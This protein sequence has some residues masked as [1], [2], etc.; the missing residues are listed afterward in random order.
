MNNHNNITEE[1]TLTKIIEEQEPAT[2]GATATTDLSKEKSPSLGSSKSK[3]K[4]KKTKNSAK[5]ADSSVSS[6]N[7]PTIFKELETKFTRPELKKDLL[8]YISDYMLGILG[9]KA[10]AQEQEEIVRYVANLFKL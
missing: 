10:T 6:G 2:K 7:K 5:S 9:R 1:K 8:S 3:S 4:S